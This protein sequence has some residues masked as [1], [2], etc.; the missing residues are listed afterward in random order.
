[1]HRTALMLNRRSA[2]ARPTAT[3]LLPSP[4]GVGLIAVT[5]TRRPRAGRDATWSGSFALCF[6]YS[7]RSSAV[8]PRSLATSRIGRGLTLLAISMSDGTL[9]G[10]EASSLCGIV[11]PV[12]AGGLRRVLRIGMF[13]ETPAEPALDAQVAERDRVVERRR[14]FYDLAVL[15]V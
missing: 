12:S 15:D 8:R 7:S 10:T 11:A 3:V 5:R 6:P 9:S 14:G 13:D 1:M 2:C 4:A